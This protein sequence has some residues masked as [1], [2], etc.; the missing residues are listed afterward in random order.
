MY[1]LRSRCCTNLQSF[2]KIIKNTF[3]NLFCKYFRSHFGSH[4]H[5]IHNFCCVRKL[6]TKSSYDGSVNEQE[7]WSWL[8]KVFIYIFF[9]EEDYSLLEDDSNTLMKKLT[10]QTLSREKNYR[11]S[12]L[13]TMTWGLASEVCAW[14]YILLYCYQWNGTAPRVYIK[15][16]LMQIWKFH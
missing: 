14:G 4:L 9:K 15:G 11:K 5:L 6:R 7:Q 12:T 8:S 2:S 13:K 16:T 1:L 10:H 3:L